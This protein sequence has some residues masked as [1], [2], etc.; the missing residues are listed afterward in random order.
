M[1]EI[2]RVTPAA[3]C[4]H[5][6]TELAGEL[7]ACPSC[8]TLVHSNEL[9]RLAETAQ[10]ATS[11]ADA[12]AAWRHALALLPPG[13]KQTQ[14]IEQKI[15]QLCR[16]VDSGGSGEATQ[17]VGD[18]QH[19]KPRRT[20]VLAGLGAIGVLLMKFKFAIVFLLTKGKLLLLGL[21]KASTF[22]SMLLSLGV[23][24][25]LWGWKFAL[26]FVLSIYIHEMGH[27][28]MLRRFGIRASAP[29]FIPGFGAVVLLRE[30]LTS[31]IEDA[32]VGLAGPFWGLG[33]ATASWGL[34]I[35]FH[36]PMF[37][38]IAKTGAWINLFNLMPVWQLDGSRAFRALSRVQRGIAA[39]ML[40]ATLFATSE[41]LL[42]LVLVVAAVRIFAKDADP[43]GD[44]RTLA[45]YAFL[46]AALS[47]LTLV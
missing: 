43:Q 8:G 32:R 26:G 38:A 44:W 1:P 34:S 19:Q 28:A 2:A 47:A 9:K 24:W 31:P 7:L 42:L 30:K 45:D 41:H 3:P 11:G 5:C 21:T 10:N 39:V 13:T 46:T 22:F 6:G 14:A 27:V 12:L 15:D 16:T 20:G 35:A 36:S 4:R 18:S 29:M 37:A 23:Y 17:P 33:A 40:L 25:N